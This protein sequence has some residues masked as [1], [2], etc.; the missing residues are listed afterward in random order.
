MG[1]DKK[2]LEIA[3]MR[4]MDTLITELTSLFREVWVSANDFF[5]SP[6]AR[7]LPDTVGS[8]PLAG[9]YQGLTHC[10]GA[11]LYVTACD[12]P[13][14]S[15]PYIAYMRE[16]ISSKAPDACVTRREDG[17]IEPFNSFFHKRCVGTLYDA[18]TRKEYKIRPFLDKLT[19]HIIEPEIAARYGDG[20]FYNINTEEDLARARGNRRQ[21]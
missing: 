2:N 19:L 15:P 11:Y 17:F 10:T 18:L 4:V 20:L 1:Y 14:I 3:G 6:H 9:I 8:G 16:I 13:F 21:P 7:T 5:T 12:M